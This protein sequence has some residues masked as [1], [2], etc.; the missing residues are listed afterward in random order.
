MNPLT[1][2][3]VEKAEED[4]LGASCLLAEHPLPDIIC[5][6]CQQSA[7]K[8]LKARLQQAMIPFPKTHDL[9]QLLRLLAPVEP[10]WEELLRPHLRVLREHAID[11]R[12]PGQRATAEHAQLAMASCQIVRSVVRKGL[13]LDDSPSQV[14]EKRAGYVLPPRKRTRSAKRKSS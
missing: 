14:K 6:H 5:Y 8:Y 2:E 13:G 1:V 11:F 10:S 7:E 3:W 12:Y 9:W 4:F